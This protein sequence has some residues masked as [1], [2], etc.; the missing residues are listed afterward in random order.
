M[1]E[2]TVR[3]AKS[4]C[5]FTRLPYMDVD[6]PLLQTEPPIKMIQ[7]LFYNESGL[8]V[9]QRAWEENIRAEVSDALGAVCEDSC[10]EFFLSPVPETGKYFNVEVNPLGNV[11]FGFGKDRY[12]LIRL[13]P[14]EKEYSLD[15]HTNVLPDGWD[16]RYRFPSA[17]IELFFPGFALQPGARMTCNC[18]KCA[19]RSTSRHYLTWNPITS[20]NED[21]H[22]TRDFGALMLD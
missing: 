16:V 3:Y 1:R 21:F 18:Y 12:S 8:Y 6:I 10:M 4:G 17:L 11:F 19:D 15:I 7:Q 13:F 20:D 9:Y 14:Q 5:E 22:V 2:Y